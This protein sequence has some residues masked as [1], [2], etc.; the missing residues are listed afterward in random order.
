[1]RLNVEKTPFKTETLNLKPKKEKTMNNKLEKLFNDFLTSYRNAND[2]EKSMHVTFCLNL[3]NFDYH[4][5]EAEK[6]SGKIVE[7]ALKG[8]ETY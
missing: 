5:K 2:E 4:V 8:K 1:V 3:K 7:N 6:Q